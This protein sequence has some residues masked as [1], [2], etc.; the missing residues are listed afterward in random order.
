MAGRAT[1]ILLVLLVALGLLA[2]IPASAQSSIFVSPAGNDSHGG[3]QADPLRELQTAVER[4]GPNT[5]IVVAAGTY[6][7]VEITDRSGL[8]IV[9][10][11][12][13]VVTSNAY[14]QR[15][16]VLVLRSSDI[17]IEGLSSQRNLWGYSVHESHGVTLRRVGVD[18]VGQE[19]IAIRDFSSNVTVTDSVISRTGRRPGVHPNGLAYASFGEGVYLGTGHSP[20]WED[21]TNGIVIRGNEISFTTAEAIDVK[22]SVYDVEIADNRIHDID[23]R[24]SGAVVVG[25]GRRVYPNPQVEIIGNFIWN[26]SSNS[27]YADGNGISLSAAATVTG[28][29]I[30]GTEHFGILLDGNFVSPDKNVVAQNNAIWETGLDPIG[31]WPSPNPGNLMA[32]GNLLDDDAVSRVGSTAP[33]TGSFPTQAAY[34]TRD[35]LAGRSFES[36]P[37]VVSP[38]T[39][40][41][42]APTTTAAP[43][44]TSP[45]PST[46]A[47]PP[48]SRPAT[49]TT[50]PA[51]PRPSTTS[52]TATTSAAPGSST[53]PVPPPRDEALPT[54]GAGGQA[55][56]PSADD[57]S[58]NA[59][60]SA[61]LALDPGVVS[62]GP[63]ASQTPGGG[64]ST[65]AGPRPSASDEEPER[66]N[67]A[68]VATAQL[69][70]IDQSESPG[71][72]SAARTL[73]PFAISTLVVGAWLVV[74][75]LAG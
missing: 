54:A 66:E 28:N 18:D 67:A 39:T 52:G 3:G 9:A 8:T 70:F 42:I 65:E 40:S 25:I 12:G 23:T 16:G 1:G 34:A 51:P 60:P 46:T 62:V 6:R 50:R 47:T 63:A 55:P 19:G 69:A 14:D 71:E 53:A 74:R 73:A 30:W 10:D 31:Q 4:A 57:R 21:T 36:T 49:T 44:T 38:T 11:P 24:T 35:L 68:T 72:T 61:D 64:A 20:G 29:V 37:N 56:T 45:A 7:A 33:T 5:T 75:R 43:P 59:T 26:I 41:T 48:T 58:P 17:T 27:P 32:S 2:P 13:A 22:A 15:A